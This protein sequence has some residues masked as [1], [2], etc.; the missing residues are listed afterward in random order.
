MNEANQTKTCSKCK[1]VKSV[2]EFNKRKALK[3]GLQYKC[4]SCQRKYYKTNNDEIK[5]Q[6]KLWYCDNSDI[7]KRKSNQY[8]KN[9]ITKIH[10][11]RNTIAL[12]D[13]YHNQLTVDEEPRLANDDQS[14]EVRCKYCGKYFKPTNSEVS[15]RVQTIKGKRS[16]D[17]GLYCSEG[18]RY[19]CPIYKQIKYPKDHKP[20]TSREV[21]PQLRKL[22]LKRD[23][24]TC[25]KCESTDTLHC[26][27]I[28]PVKINPIESADVDNCIT[29]CKN[30]HKEVHQVDG[31]TTGQLAAC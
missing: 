1:E 25:Q 12:Y 10:Q 5:K 9:N 23:N 19:S 14:L 2:S 24:Y 29:L 18:C 31:C 15:R 20:A 3:D 26:H 22:V 6:R 7:V 8:R 16:G 13:T 30:C 21:Q 27:H 17:H 4:R 11:Y 28:D